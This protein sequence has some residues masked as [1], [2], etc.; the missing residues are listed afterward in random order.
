MVVVV[1]E[2]AAWTFGEPERV[3]NGRIVC[4]S[5]QD[6]HRLAHQTSSEPAKLG[7]LVGVLVLALGEAR[8]KKA[9][10]LRVA[11]STTKMAL[12]CD[13]GFGHIFFW[14]CELRLC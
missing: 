14:T 3:E 2:V 6:R 4:R 7:I 8:R 10:A 1:E 11:G 5:R 12:F 13:S 9:A